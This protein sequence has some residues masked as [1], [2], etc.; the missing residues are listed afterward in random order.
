MTEQAIS[1]VAE[2]G[3]M[4]AGK[5]LTLALGATQYGIEILKVREI[6]GMM[7]IT[8]IPRTPELVL[9]VTNLRG[10]I[11][12]VLDLR[13]IFG[14]ET[15][16]DSDETRTIVVEMGGVEVGIVVD[17]V[18]EVLDVD[19]EEI[20]DAPSFGLAIDTDFVRGMGKKDGQVSIL[21]DIDKILGRNELAEIGAMG[22]D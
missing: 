16:K 8:Q 6:I 5:Y 20:E 11:I 4:R 13:R 15:L 12:P 1:S 19:E 9:G 2:T 18:R 17:L 7:E 10:K 3:S 21:L 14:M 22:L